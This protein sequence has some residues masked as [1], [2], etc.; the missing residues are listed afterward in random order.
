MISPRSMTTATSSK[1]Q[2]GRF[3]ESRSRQARRDQNRRVQS[4]A[5]RQY[6]GGHRARDLHSQS[7]AAGPEQPHR[8]LGETRRRRRKTSLASGLLGFYADQSLPFG[9][10][11]NHH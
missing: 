4:A 5:L 6:G 7:E 9:R 10:Q 8:D 11:S 3:V 1:N 2:D